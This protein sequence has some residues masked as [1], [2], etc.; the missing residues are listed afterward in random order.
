MDM[1]LE[2]VRAVAS[3]IYIMHMD[4]HETKMNKTWYQILFLMLNVYLSKVV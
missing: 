2:T 1:A 3:M 4:S